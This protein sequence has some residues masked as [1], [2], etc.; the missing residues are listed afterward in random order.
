MPIVVSAAGVHTGGGRT[1]LAGL[2]SAL[3]SDDKVLLDR[4]YPAAAESTAAQVCG[5]SPGLLGRVLGERMLWRLARDADLV[6]C[7]NGMPPLRRLP[8]RAAVFL[9][10]KLLIDPKAHR[11][12]R[13]SVRRFVLR[14]G[15]PNTDI[16]IV[17]TETMA[18]LARA[19]GFKNVLVAPVFEWLPAQPAVTAGP[20]CDF[21][22]PADG[23][24]HKNHARLFAAWERLARSGLRPHLGVTLADVHA[25]VWRLAQPAIAAGAR[26]TNY[27]WI[28]RE[29]TLA[30]L[31]NARALVFPSQEESFGLPLVEAQMLNR[32]I[33]AS[34]LDYVRDVARP[35]QTFDP[36][37]D[38]SI[39]RAVRR[40]LGEAEDLH[41]AHA[42]AAWLRKVVDYSK[43]V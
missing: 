2:L 3:G 8:A 12:W 34:E 26:I 27:G 11:G 36:N 42:P 16:A 29:E 6:L 35:S 25:D 15:I 43:T 22:Y 9:Q 7:L 14:R 32:P 18:G 31:S 10:N 17:Q 39:A 1:I 38:I 37:S 23:Q 21:F 33:I 4:R 20:P 28:S 13:L 19:T 24:P 41:A 5:V 40:F 30:L